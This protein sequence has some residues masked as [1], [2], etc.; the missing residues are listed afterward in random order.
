MT[1]EDVHGSDGMGDSFFPKAKQRP[2]EKHA[3]DFI[4]E[5]VKANPGE[6]A[7]LSNCAVNEYCDGNQEGSNNYEGY[8]PYLYYGR[9]K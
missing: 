3:I 1:V 7:L 9:H 4:I 6:I 2:E 8:S 5:T